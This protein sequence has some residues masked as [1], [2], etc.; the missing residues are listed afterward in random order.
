[1]P[2]DE[3]LII[4]GLAVVAVLAVVVLGLLRARR[5]DRDEVRQQQD[6]GAAQREL[7]QRLAPPSAGRHSVRLPTGPGTQANDAIAGLRGDRDQVAPADDEST[8][9]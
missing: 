5:S 3:Y 4:G 8:D 6:L 9:G 1:M 2:E 7:G